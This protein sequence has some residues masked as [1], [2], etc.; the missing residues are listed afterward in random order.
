MVKVK[1]LLHLAKN[2]VYRARTKHIDLKY[3]KLWELIE[4]CDM[5]LQKIP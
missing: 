5:F 2:N 4:D 3:D 1:V